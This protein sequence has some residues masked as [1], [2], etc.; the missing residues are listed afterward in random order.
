VS[1]TSSLPAPAAHPNPVALRLG[2]AGL[3]PF[4]IGALL[5]MLIPADLHEGAV[6]DFV[7][8]GLMAYAAAIV[9]FLGG[10]QWG[11]GMRSSVPSPVPFAWG[12]A[13]SLLAWFAMLLPAHAGLVIAGLSLVACYLV[14]RRSYP[15]H[16]M[17][18]WMTLRF[19]LTLVAS[20]CC[21]LAAASY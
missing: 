1:L 13:P 11:L 7:F 16:G 18:G 19:R 17:A 12:V 10:I 21:F 9:S 5:T 2:Y 8:H 6:L 20:L 15:G 14:D 3:A 4:V